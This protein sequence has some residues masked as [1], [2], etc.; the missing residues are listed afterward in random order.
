MAEILD[1]PFALAANH[2]EPRALEGEAL[3]RFFVGDFFAPFIQELITAI[4]TSESFQ[5]LLLI[6]HRGCG[7]TTL[8]NRVAGELRTRYHLVYFSAGEV[9]NMMDVETVDILLA[10]YGKV[11][12]S[13]EGELREERLLPQFQELIKRGKNKFQ[14]DGKLDINAFFF[15]FT[16]ESEN[17]AGMRQ[18]L[19]NHM[20]DL[21]G[22][23]SQACADV[24]EKT[25]KEVLII[26]DNLDK[27]EDAIAQNIFLKGSRLLTLPRAKVLFTMPLPT[28]YDPGFIGVSD[29]AYRSVFIPLINLSGREGNLLP[30]NLAEMEQVALRRIDER[31]LE[32]AALREMVLASGGLLRDLIKFMHMACT[33]AIVKGKLEGREVII[34]QEIAAQVIRDLVNQYTRVFD[35]P[36]YRDAITHIRQTKD[37]EQVA[38]EDMSFFLHNLFA[39]EYGHPDRIWYDLHPCLGRA[40]DGE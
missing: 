24:R 35:F 32:K 26:I 12:E 22:K 6:G 16:V 7:K 17:R 29:V 38:H 10:T 2:F 33:R 5:K 14:S 34:D 11:V 27:L 8:L 23:L 20:E 1:S 30:D 37:K 39:L 28:Y 36:K 18:T 4:D 21:Q 13:V 3:E 15:R 9:L 40:L 25:G 19:R 31:L